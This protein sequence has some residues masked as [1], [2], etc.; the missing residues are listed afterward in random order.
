MRL[1]ATLSAVSLKV[2]R[3]PQ[4]SQRLH[5]LLENRGKQEQVYEIRI[6]LRAATLENDFR[7]RGRVPSGPVAAGVGDR[8]IRVSDAHDSGAERN[9][10]S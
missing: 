6:E 5:D 7:G 8:I 9:L 1:E 3:P 10:R 4:L 2:R